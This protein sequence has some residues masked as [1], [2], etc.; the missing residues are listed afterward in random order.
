MRISNLSGK[1][2]GTFQA[3]GFERSHF[4]AFLEVVSDSRLLAPV[5]EH[6]RPLGRFSKE[7]C[8]DYSP[9]YGWNTRSEP[10]RL[11]CVDTQLARSFQR[12]YRT[13]FVHALSLCVH[14]AF[15]RSSLLSG[16]SR[17]QRRPAPL[18]DRY[19]HGSDCIFIIQSP[20]GKRSGAH[21][22]SA[23]EG[24]GL[25]DLHPSRT[26]ARR[27]Q[28]EIGAEQEGEYERERV[29]CRE[30]DLAADPSEVSLGGAL[31]K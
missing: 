11:R 16:A 6:P 21:F 8:H 9:K 25:E 17:S 24:E 10:N 3:S 20:I 1:S 14:G 5:Y 7:R 23:I 4:S 19:P 18:D 12:E 30:E 27:A 22:N 29:F 26:G 31:V 2:H 13:G 28:A 15:L